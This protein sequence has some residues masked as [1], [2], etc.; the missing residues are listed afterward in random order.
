MRT[1]MVQRRQ[2]APSQPLRPLARSKKCPQHRTLMRSPQLLMM[3][4]LSKKPLLRKFQKLRLARAVL[5][6]SSTRVVAPRKSG[7]S[8]MRIPSPHHRPRLAPSSHSNLVLKPRRSSN[9]LSKFRSTLKSR[10]S[11]SNKSSRGILHVS[12]LSAGEKPCSWGTSR[13]ASSIRTIRR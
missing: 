5:Q 9:R 12:G 10:Q 1:K 11:S 2:M 8:R 13:A 6:L 3:K 4:S 7:S